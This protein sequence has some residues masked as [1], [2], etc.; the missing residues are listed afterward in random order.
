M[1]SPILSPIVQREVKTS[2]GVSH[3]LRMYVLYILQVPISQLGG[4]CGGIQTAPLPLDTGS[5][6]ER[7]IT[8]V[9]I[10]HSK[11]QLRKLS[12]TPNNLEK[13]ASCEKM[14]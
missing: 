8:M 10:P 4:S 9:G 3:N 14:T 5:V 6:F 1:L 2:S 12:S 7:S 11:E 13:T